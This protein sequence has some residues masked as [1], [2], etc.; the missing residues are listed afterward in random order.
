MDSFLK[1]YDITTDL[2]FKHSYY[3]TNMQYE[4][5]MLECKN[6]VFRNLPI[7]AG[8]GLLLTISSHYL[9]QFIFFVIIINFIY[10]GSKE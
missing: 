8:Y 3:S 1:C 5:A 7:A 9:F 4:N 6:N 2:H 10:L